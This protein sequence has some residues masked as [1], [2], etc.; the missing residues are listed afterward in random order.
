MRLS[1]VSPFS[2]AEHRRHAVDY[3][4]LAEAAGYEAVWMPE[5][6]G[7]DAF[8]QLGLLAGQTSRLKLAT[9][10]VNVFS[11]SPSLLA[12]SFATLD[13]MSRG[14][15]I[16]GL[17]TSGPV[18]IERWHG[19]KFT[20]PLARTQETVAII[21]LALSGG[22][23]EH[24]GE[25]FRLSGFR[26]SIRPVQERMPLYLATLKPRSV[27]LTGRIADGWLP[28]H[29][30]VRHLDG[31]RR[32]LAEAARSAGRDPDDIDMA[33][34]TLVAYSRD[35]ETARMQC[36][37]HLAYYVGSMGR[38][39]HELL[40]SYGYGKVA[41]RV[42]SAWK[43]GNR[44]AAAAAIPR[45]VLDDLVIAGNRAECLEAMQIRRGA[46]FRHIVIFPPHGSSVEQVKATLT[47]M[48]PVA[49]S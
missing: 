49:A 44:A 30:S 27:H 25:F 2:S 8:T 37:E 18:V 42:R 17:G 45:P 9:G 13:E 1:Y 23:V 14:R 33:V 31:L 38:F 26:L 20:K 34:M 11:R 3:A 16:I 41:D 46:G 10:I 12:Q 19:S 40:H 36:R 43:A 32:P 21:R 35:G 47:A 6:F 24:D 29:V 28:T 4:Q 48:A 39:Y 22:R 15:A 5:A 7:S